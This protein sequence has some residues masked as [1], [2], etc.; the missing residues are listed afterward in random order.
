M[1]KNNTVSIFLVDD[2]AMYRAGIRASLSKAGCFT[3]DIIGEAGSGTEFFAALASGIIPEMVILDIILPD[4]TGVEIARYLKTKHPDTKIIILSAEV[5]PELIHELLDI[6][7]DGYMSKL[8]QIEDIQNAV[9]SVMGGVPY[10]GRSVMKIMYDIYI[11]NQ[12]KTA[13]K[14]EKNQFKFFKKPT[15]TYPTLTERENEIAILLCEGMQLKEIG[16]KL[17]ISPRTVESHKN[18]MFTKLGFSRMIDL[19]K[20]AVKEGLV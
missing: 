8:A 17:N 9:C 5:T 20:Y 4:T 10:Y 18:N 7:V 19:I 2:H 15:R 16:E 11:T 14:Q 13:L 12:H 6:G 1:K 3:P